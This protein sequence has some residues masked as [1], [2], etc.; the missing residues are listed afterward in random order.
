M[1]FAIALVHDE[2]L[3]VAAVMRSDAPFDGHALFAPDHHLVHVGAFA[4]EQCPDARPWTEWLRESLMVQA[5]RTLHVDFGGPRMLD[6]ACTLEAI[7]AAAREGRKVHAHVEAWLR[8]TLSGQRC[9]AL[10]LRRS[11]PVS[12]IKSLER[13]RVNRLKAFAQPGTWAE[14]AIESRR[15]VLERIAQRRIDARLEGHYRAHLEREARR[16]A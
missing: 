7:A 11:I 13:V 3:E 9:D 8:T 6:P 1:N 12:V 10:G 2:T 15:E 16:K 4:D 14:Q 5:D